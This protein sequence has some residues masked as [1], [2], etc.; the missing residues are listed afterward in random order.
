MVPPGEAA[1]PFLSTAPAV[2]APCVLASFG[3]GSVAVLLFMFSPAFVFGALACELPPAALPCATAAVLASATA[4][5][6]EIHFMFIVG[7][8]SVEAPTCQ[9]PLPSSVPRR[10]HGKPGKSVTSDGAAAGRH[11]VCKFVAW[12]ACLS[13]LGDGPNNNAQT[14]AWP[15][16]LAV[17][18]VNEARVQRDHA[19]LASAICAEKDEPS[20]RAP[21]FSINH[22][23]TG[24][25]DVCLLP[26]RTECG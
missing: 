9:L 1:S 22:Q 12:R 7:V 10:V 25:A 16:A 4:A 24:A 2:P 23:S 19:V 15:A 18:M 21:K 8:R 11:S 6:S 3:E 13:A 5:A 20:S 17:R 14:H 26:M